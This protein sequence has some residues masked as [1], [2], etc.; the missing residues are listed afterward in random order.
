M[1]VKELLKNN[2]VAVNFYAIKDAKGILFYNNQ[3][4]SIAAPEFNNAIDCFVLNPAA[5]FLVCISDMKN[6]AE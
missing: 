2:Q 3:E 1:G 4:Q 6:T 5:K